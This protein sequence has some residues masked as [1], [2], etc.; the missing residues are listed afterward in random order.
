MSLVLGAAL[1]AGLLL[2]ASP[3]LWP[4]AARTRERAARRGALTA[5][6]EDAGLPRTPPRVLVVAQAAIA[7]A[8]AA[9]AWLV[10]AA[11]VLALLAAV[12]AAAA[13]V[14]WLR[15]RAAG[16]VRRRRAMWPDIC[17][18]LIGSVRAGLSLPDAVSSLAL[19][20]PADLRA[21]FARFDR[22]MRA[23]GHF[24]SSLDRLKHTLSDPLADRI[25]ETL[26][27]A[28]EVGGTE[29]VPVLKALSTSIRADQALRGE[30][31][32]RQSWTRGAAVLGACAPWAILAML[33]MRPEGAE[34]YATPTGVAIIL[35]GAA[36]SLVS[37]R[38]MIR[39]G[40]LPEPRRW[41]A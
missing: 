18:L 13:P 7:A 28:R 24:S 9:I 41:F 21:P 8:A 30:A 40:R 26:R 2:V 4:A 12:A 31:E 22:D 27:M 15:S 14:V 17:D 33:S 38:L 19:S 32:S 39:L 3:W 37:Y 34:A 1:G 36:V 35:A 23:S 11:P 10:T 20:A 16:L 29:L 25:I 6:L 5:L